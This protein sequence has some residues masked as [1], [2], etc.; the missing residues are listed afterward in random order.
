MKTKKEPFTVTSDSKP[1]K[2]V[3]ADA[4][5][6]SP[7]SKERTTGRER[8]YS[9]KLYPLSFKAKESLRYSLWEYLSGLE[10]KAKF[11]PVKAGA[12]FLSDQDPDLLIKEYFLAKSNTRKKLLRFTAKHINSFKSVLKVLD[13]SIKKGVQEAYDGAIDLL[14]E[15]GEILLIVANNRLLDSVSNTGDVLNTEEKEEKWEV[16]IKG[17]ACAQSIDPQQRFDTITK[18]IPTQKRRLVKAAI[19]DALL[20]MENEINTDS[21]N[22]YLTRFSSSD[23]PDDYIQKYA[24][25]ALE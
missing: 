16:L 3:S 1:K 20:I 2:S 9:P 25:E 18:L 22:S 10:S 11:S 23:E 17:I 12:E 8:K 7:L 21:I 13:W 4:S 6:S 15:C 24:K 5:L 19:I 14:A